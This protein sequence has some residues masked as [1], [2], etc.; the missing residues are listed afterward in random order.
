MTG[1]FRSFWQRFR[2]AQP[3]QRFQSLYRDRQSQRTGRYSYQF[4]I[5]V[6][7]G[8]VLIIAGLVLVPAP[9]PGWLIVALGFALLAREFLMVARA[10]DAIEIK[11][12]N[13]LR[14]CRGLAKAAR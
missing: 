5:S 2:T 9:G 12:R 10:L 1:K 11:L 13:W 4:I 14:W 7:G 8:I 6:A 3:G